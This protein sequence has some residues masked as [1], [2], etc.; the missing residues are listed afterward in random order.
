MMKDAYGN[1]VVQRVIDYADDSQRKILMEAIKP[2]I[3]NLRRFT[4][5]KH[6]IARI[7]LS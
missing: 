3:A 5:G 6:I 7:G 4:Y 1:F 2:H